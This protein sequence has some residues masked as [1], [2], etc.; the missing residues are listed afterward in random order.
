MIEDGEVRHD[1]CMYE[2]CSDISPNWMD[3]RSE[4]GYILL[5]K[6]NLSNYDFKKVR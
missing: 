6:I 2:S 4:F 5:S 1:G 3:M